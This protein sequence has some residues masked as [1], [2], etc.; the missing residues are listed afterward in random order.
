MG[1]WLSIWYKWFTRSKDSHCFKEVL[2]RLTSGNVQQR[3]NALD[4]ISELIC[5]SSD[6]KD[7]L[8]Q[9]A[10]YA[11]CSVSFY[12]FVILWCFHHSAL[13]YLFPMIIAGKILQTICLSDLKME[14]LQFGNK[15][16]LCFQWLVRLQF[17]LFHAKSCLT[18]S[19]FFAI[20]SFKP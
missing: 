16:P 10:W 12:Y 19:R 7:K 14:K 17:K 1:T 15:H 13:L 9:L 4:V 20:Y 3:T 8:S 18:F 11:K 5:M 2:E 6:S